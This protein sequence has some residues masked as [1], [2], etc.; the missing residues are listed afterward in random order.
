MRRLAEKVVSQ[1]QLCP[2][3]PVE[4]SALFGERGRECGQLLSVM[5][6]ATDVDVESLSCGMQQGGM[7]VCTPVVASFERGTSVR[8]AKGPNH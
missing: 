7:D 4:P 1:Q 8:K 6:R 2:E 3:G 5:S